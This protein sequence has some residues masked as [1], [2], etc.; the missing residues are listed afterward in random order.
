MGGKCSPLDTFPTFSEGNESHLG[1]HLK[2]EQK[3]VKKLVRNGSG[4]AEE[5]AGILTQDPSL[6]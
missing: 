2:N 1:V 6:P 5:F 3:L 4:R